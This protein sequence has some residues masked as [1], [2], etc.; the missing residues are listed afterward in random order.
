[1]VSCAQDYRLCGSLL[2]T[3]LQEDSTSAPG[4]H[5]ALGRL[6]LHLGDIQAAETCFNRS[7]P[8]YRSRPGSTE[9]TKNRRVSR[10]QSRDGLE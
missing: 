4:L 2:K 6:H 5:S 1:M 8:G 7:A 10:S 3:L 9:L